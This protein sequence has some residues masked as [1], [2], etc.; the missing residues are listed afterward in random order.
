MKTGCE[1]FGHDYDNAVEKGRAVVCPRCG[2]DVSQHLRWFPWL[3]HKVKVV[4][5]KKESK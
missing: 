2:E 4:K 1:S 5:D 3:S